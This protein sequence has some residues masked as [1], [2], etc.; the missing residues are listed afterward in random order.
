MSGISSI[1]SRTSSLMMSTQ[2]Q[3]RLRDT[4]LQLLRAQTQM[5]TGKSVVRPS[6]DPAKASA[7]LF[8]REQLAAR[9]QYSRNL[10]HALSLLNNAD[11]ALGE[12]ND[13][14]I[15]ARS[16]ASSQVGVG[17]D[18]DTRRTEA[19][20]IDA[21]IKAMID[22]ANRQIDGI[23]LFGGNQGTADGQNVFEEFLGG[24]RYRGSRTNLAGEVGASRSQPFTSNG[25]DAF[26]ALSSRIQ[27]LIDLDPQAAATTRLVDVD[28]AQLQGVRLGTITIDVDGTEVQ[29]DLTGSDTL[30]DVVT[31]VNDAI[32]SVDAAAGAL[33]I[34]GE[35][36]A[37][38]ANAGHTI[39]I[40]DP[41]S[42][43]TAADLGIDL[44]VTATTTAGSA[45]NIKLTELT[46]LTDLGT[47]VDFAAGLTI[48]QGETT[49]TADF[50]SAET[51]QDLMNV[52]DELGLGLRLQI[53]EDADGLDLV[54]EVS[55][56]RLSVGEN[57]G[58]T[59]ADLG[60]GTYLASTLLSDFRDGR[61]V[62]AIS[63]DDDFAITLHDGT[64]FNVNI[65][66]VTTVGELMTAIE[67]AATTAGVA[68]GIDFTVSLATVGNG[69]TL[70]DNT[71]GA[72]DF[73]VEN[74][75]TSLAAT[76][77]GLARNAGADATI[78]GDDDTKIYVDSLF[79]H[80][81][82]LRNSLQNDSTSGIT[83]AGSRLETDLQTV[84][85][86]RAEVGV[87]SQR[88]EQQKNRSSEQELSEKTMLSELR[89]ADLTEVITRFGQ[90]QMQLQASLQVGAQNLQLSLLDFLR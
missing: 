40:T 90:L 67:D 56:L 69:L 31:R 63:G 2:L 60:L 73:K 47:A 57:G 38:T 26:G 76:N 17:S 5:T 89:D 14:L 21:Q 29:L 52:V 83:L 62:Q 6:D 13:I 18:A 70:N 53:N 74:L 7:I 30:G 87:Q 23:A 4:Q 75:G 11:A 66:G 34:S 79:T 10:D 15:D 85:Q 16:I 65:D 50:S 49:K 37:L 46:A 81:I 22:I 86:A 59:A 78:Q 77:L 45:L 55:G 51:I 43:Q 27:S 58:T 19:N 24:I 1:Y 42:G 28:G 39:T 35:G 36:F 54:S 64:T 84:T 44:D 33:S 72:S 48:T 12:A 25:A 68:V 20:I 82:D 32:D 41:G 88:V 80:L 8:L 3:A 61:G 9:T 71:A